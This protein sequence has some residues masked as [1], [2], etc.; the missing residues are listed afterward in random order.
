M[1]ANK[2]RSLLL[3][4]ALGLG[5]NQ[6]YAATTLNVWIRASNDSKNIYTRDH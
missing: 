6:S 1:S 5:I 2:L 4:T 3:F